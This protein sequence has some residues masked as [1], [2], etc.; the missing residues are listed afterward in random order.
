[1]LGSD[2]LPALSERGHEVVAPSSKELDITDPTSVAQ[3]PAGTFGKFDWVVN[4]AAYTAVDKAESEV[5]EATELNALAPGYLAHACATAGGFALPCRLLHVSTDFVFD[6]SATEP[7]DEDAETNPLGVYG[8]TKRD[9]ERAVLEAQPSA[10]VVRTSWLYGPNGGSFPRTILRAWLAGKTL[11]VVSDQTGS[12]TYTAD[13]ARSIAD[14]VESNPYPGI[15]QA[16]GP[17]TLSWQ[18]F[19]VKALEAWNRVHKEAREIDV[20]PI[21]TEDWPTPATRPKYSALS[22]RKIRDAGVAAMRPVDE[23]LTEFVARLGT[24]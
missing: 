1:M 4:C 14:L 19:A 3:I 17:D 16:T 8:R 22:N 5:R 10:V 23:A 13:L 6:G 12:P 7:Y 20:A 24:P 11:R 2:L 9:G 21:K 15:Y 18:Q